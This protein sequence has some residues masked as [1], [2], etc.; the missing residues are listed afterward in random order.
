MDLVLAEQVASNYL[1]SKGPPGSSE[2]LRQLAKTVYA[3]VEL[4]A[5]IQKTLQVVTGRKSISKSLGR[6]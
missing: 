5:T 2:K 1:E 6:D 3:E 4:G